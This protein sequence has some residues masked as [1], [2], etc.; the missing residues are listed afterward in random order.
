MKRNVL[1][2]AIA[3]MSFYTANAQTATEDAKLFDNIYV[4]VLG[5]AATPL[6]FNSVFPLNATAGLK[7]GKELTPV[8]GIEVEGTAL[9]NGN[10]FTDASTF[11]KATNVSLNGTVSLSNL[12]SGYK[13]SRRSF[14]LKTNTGIGWLRTIENKTSYVTAKTGLDFQFAFGAKKSSAIAISPAVYWNLNKT[15]YA[16]FNRDHAQFALM[17]SYLYFFKTSNGTHYFKTYDMGAMLS[18]LDRLN[19]ELAKKPKEVVREVVKE[20]P[21]E[22]KVVTVNS[23]AYV[24]FAQDSSILTDEAKAILDKVEGTVDIV[25]YA[26]PEGA[27]AYNQA[28][29]EKRAAVVAD[30]LTK[31]G[32]TVNSWKGGGVPDK[33]SGRVAVVTI[34]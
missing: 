11:V 5:G 2:M 16:N 25:G 19:E 31:K 1:T 14:E 13:G 29:S 15:H 21:G 28:L 10:H 18:E 30:Y 9:F 12:I 6:D 7:L 3:V 24:F 27:N 20:V 22:T 32:V 26:S 4:G 23:D 33:T 34:K 17:A 8:F